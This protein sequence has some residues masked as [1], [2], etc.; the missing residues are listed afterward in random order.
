[1]ITLLRVFLLGFSEAHSSNGMTYDG[2]PGC[3]KSR[4]YDRG[5]N[6]RRR[7]KA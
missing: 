4:A 2:D 3:A 6:L 5:R 7:G 1:M